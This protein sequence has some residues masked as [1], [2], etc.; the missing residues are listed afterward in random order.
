MTTERLEN[1]ALGLLSG[2]LLAL[3][4]LTPVLWWLHYVALVPWIVL[5]TRERGRA[6][7][8]Y[9]LAGAYTFY[10]MA[11]GPLSLF[12]KA[13]PFVLA[14]LYA[15][16]FVPFAI[17][18]R[19]L[20]RRLRLPL[21]LL[22]PVVWVS[23]EWLRLRYSI[24]EVGF[25][26]LGSSQFGR[27]KLIQIADV[28]G[29]YGVSFLVAAA[30]GAVFD[31]WH[32]VRARTASAALPVASWVLVLFAV[33]WYG[34]DRELGLRLTAG[35]R[36]ALVQPNAIHYRDPRRALETYEQELAFTRSAVPPGG[37]DVVAWP[38]NAIGQPLGDD[39]RYLKGL[40]ELA[41][42]ERA[43]LVVG[44][45]TAAEA[46]P[47]GF[48]HTSAY[49]ISPSGTLLG[50]YDKVHLIPWSE[51]I[52]FHGWFG[53]ANAA[54]A[55]LFLGYAGRGVPGT[56][57]VLF[58]IETTA[59]TRQFAVPI[60]FE[61]S[62]TRFG[63]AAGLAGADFLVNITSEGLLGPPIYLHMLAQ[64]TFRAVEHRIAVVRV[65]NNGF[66]GVID[67]GGHLSLMRSASGAPLFR[68][69]GTFV[70][71]VPLNGTRGRTF[72]TRY[73]DLLVY[74]CATAVALLVGWCVVR[75]RSTAVTAPVTERRP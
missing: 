55:T 43:Y 33:L 12:H 44:G 50:R 72:Y 75:A 53:R 24:G 46:P 25:F 49:Y 66:S 22:V 21:T 23:A 11:L 6:A 34:A 61:V 19:V 74:G 16:F 3:P 67:P 56:R 62:S 1:L 65:A 41:Q 27:S 28:T 20:Y 2:I 40:A 7:W 10:I 45:Y 58:P 8:L 48:F 9:A 14:L 32:A 70:V 73:G 35:P 36:V 71:R 5:L 17:L 60:C 59:G 13:V 18:V 26:P 39:P 31:A 63:R 57:V 64:S 4:F 15:P 52:P 68:Q 38:E 30:N 42:Y 54:L 69:A 51:Y 47:A 37:A 29:V